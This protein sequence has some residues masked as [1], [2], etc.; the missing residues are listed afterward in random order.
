MAD[1]MHRPA[2]HSTTYSD[3]IFRRRKATCGFRRIRGSSG[4]V[5]S[6]GS[7]SANG[8]GRGRWIYRVCRPEDLGLS[9]PFCQ[10]DDGLGEKAE[11]EFTL[12]FANAPIDWF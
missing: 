12:T 6:S 5:T 11:F 7:H 4:P 8:D 10:F 3:S 2:I 9:S 1:S